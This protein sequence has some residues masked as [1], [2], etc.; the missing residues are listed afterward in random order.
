VA[1]HFRPLIIQDIRN[2]TPDCLS[3][4]FF[5]PEEW[6]EEF[7][8]KAGQNVTLRTTI[9]GKEVRRSY[10]ICSSPYEN[11]LR[12]AI[13]K[14]EAGLFSSYAHEYFEKSQILDVLPPTGNFILPPASTNN[15]HYVAFAAGSGI[16]PVISILKTVLEENPDTRFSLIYGNQNRA[17][18]IFREELL[19]LKNDHPEQFQLINV[20][21]REKM[22]A[23]IF[24]GRLNATKCDLIFSQ[25]IPFSTDQEYLIC[26]PAQMIFSIRDW[27]RSKNV[28]DKRIHYEL[29][30]DPGESLPYLKTTD[31]GNKETSGEKSVVT[32]RLDGISAEYQIPFRGPTILEAAIQAGADLP[33]ACRAGVCATCR[34]KLVKGKVTMEQ[35]YA[36]AE[37]ELEQGFIL[38]CQSHP[39]SEKLTIDFDIR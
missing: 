26:G 32:I 25:V 19:A 36:L 11:E 38:A 29:F 35:N 37:E 30:S 8:F 3:V 22:D 18:V 24:E 16:T 12:I 10:S 23:P 21:S 28:S 39:V 34:A 9:Q 6:K 13:K 1:K 20:F 17:S 31:G 2:E 7:R 27:L 14:A 4:S 15:Q 33:Y 5:I